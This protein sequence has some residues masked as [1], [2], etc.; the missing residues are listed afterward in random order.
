[1]S[2]IV[3]L[4]KVKSVKCGHI[5]NVQNDAE[6]DNGSVGYIGAL[7]DGEREIYALE[8]FTTEKI[9]T[10]SIVLVAAPEIVYD[11]STYAKK[12]LS[13]F[14]NPAK[15]PVRAY[16][17]VAHDIFSVSDDMV[18]AIDDTDDV[19]AVD[20]NVVAQNASFKLAEIATL[21]GTEKFVG[22]IID[23]ETIGTT[24][25]VGAGGN[26]GTTTNLI[27]IEVIKN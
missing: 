4:D 8:Q 11:E 15:T 9:A 7:L 16:E 17:L 12:K 24:V 5:Y 25:P 23:V 20:N 10:E 18:T 6:L 14:V 22:K 26:V 2:G 3:R 1:M 27:A 13:A 21:A 19:V